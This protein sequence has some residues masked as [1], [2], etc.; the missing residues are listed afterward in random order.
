MCLGLDEDDSDMN[1]IGKIGGEKEHTLTVD[2]MPS[3]KHDL[4][5]KYGTG[6][7]TYGLTGESTTGTKNSDQIAATGGSEAHNNMQ[8][9]E[10]TG[11]HWIR[12]A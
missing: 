1:V 4:T 2:E 7:T 6:S 9:F 11:Y 5:L 8:P 12:R 3:H 10:I